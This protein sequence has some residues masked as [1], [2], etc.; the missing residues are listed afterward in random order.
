METMLD[1]SVLMPKFRSSLLPPFG[2][3]VFRDAW[4]YR[5]T[6]AG[7]E[8][9]ATGKGASPAFLQILRIAHGAPV[10]FAHVAGEMEHISG[11]DLELW[12]SAMCTMGLL[13][14]VDNHD[15]PA[16]A[17]R[18]HPASP[19]MP[20]APEH[21]ARPT[22]LLV[23][24]DAKARANWRRALGT[25]DFDFAE[26]ADLETVERLIRDKRPA[27]VVMGLKGA[28]FDGLHLLKALKRPRAPRVSRV[29]LV[30][31]RGK[32]LPP[33]DAEV[34]ARA[35]ATAA[36][37][38]DIV[39]AL[40][41]P[42]AESA[43]VAAAMPATL[44]VPAPDQAPL[45]TPAPAHL[46]RPAARPQA[47]A[48]PPA[49]APVWMNLLYAKSFEYGSFET[50]HASALESQYPRLMVR[51]IEGWS[52]PEF[53]NEIGELIV[54]SRGDRAGFPPE[55]MEEIWLLHQMHQSLH[56]QA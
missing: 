21:P 20:D 24:A 2:V 37:V 39:R 15:A 9:L 36:S 42:A 27:W 17:V 51:M 19:V 5:I 8:R 29:C 35:D 53:S 28:D 26:G 25:G 41:H 52:K 40:A 47:I 38:Q 31:P 10:T 4:E 49:N 55:V 33:D 22:V 56:D 54:D 16:P 7:H 50:D 43:A 14:P 1:T 13:A 34:A 32:Q 11:D 23:H 6:P 12:L 45:A 18:R 30:I 48:R 46:D 44:P 3:N